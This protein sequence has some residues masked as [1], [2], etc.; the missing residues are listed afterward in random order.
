[1]ATA[2]E[3]IPERIVHYLYPPDE[4]PWANGFNPQG[5]QPQVSAFTSG[6]SVSLKRLSPEDLGKLFTTFR[7]RRPAHSQGALHFMD[8][9]AA[10]RRSAITGR[11]PEPPPA[12]QRR[13]PSSTSVEQQTSTVEQRTSTSLAFRPSSPQ[14]AET[15]LGLP[16]TR[17]GAAHDTAFTAQISEPP[18]PYQRDG[19]GIGRAAS[20]SPLNSDQAVRPAGIARAASATVTPARTRTATPE[21][22]RASAANLQSP[23]TISAP[24]PPTSRPAPPRQAGPTR[25]VS[26]APS[27]GGPGG[28]GR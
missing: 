19:E 10:S 4:R 26:P 17:A 15:Y 12:Y 3:P 5:G 1:M 8:T 6:S 25:G 21:S 18:P 16:P 28:S 20:P 23:H 7:S 14:I 27:P 22:A 13:G 24:R 2:S 11:I 9:L